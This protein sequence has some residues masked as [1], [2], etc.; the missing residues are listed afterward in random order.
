MPVGELFLRSYPLNWVAESNLLLLI[1]ECRGA[2][3]GVSITDFVFVITS[4]E[5]VKAFSRGFNVQFGINIEVSIGPW[6]RAGEVDIVLSDFAPICG[7]L[8]TIRL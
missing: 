8:A 4:E 2:Q 3:V 7:F 5:G 1:L 6:G